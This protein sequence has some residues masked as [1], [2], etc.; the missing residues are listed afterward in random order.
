MHIDQLLYD[1]LY[2]FVDTSTRQWLGLWLLCYEKYVWHCSNR[3]FSKTGWGNCI[4]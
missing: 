3:Y 1:S 2:S 4:L